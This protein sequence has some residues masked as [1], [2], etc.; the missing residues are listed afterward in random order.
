[1]N[2]PSATIARHLGFLVMALVLVALAACSLNPFDGQTPSSVPAS[3]ATTLTRAPTLTPVAPTATIGPAAAT[4]FPTMT[5]EV[6]IL[7]ARY[8]RDITIP[9][10]YVVAPGESF[11][12]IWEIRNEGEVAW[13][14]GTVLQHVEGPSLG[15]VESVS[16]RPREPGETAEIAVEMVAPM[17]PGLYTSYWQL[18][19]GDQCFGSRIW[20]QIRVQAE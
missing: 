20:T 3:P 4:P 1:M 13:P 8:V 12:K 6:G 16:L 17:E 10:G 14:E 18:C 15:P 19:V 9:D 2:R 5:L 11:Q 7:D